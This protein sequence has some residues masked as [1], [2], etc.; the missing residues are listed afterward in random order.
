M[1][2]R[3]TGLPAKKVKRLN[4]QAAKTKNKK[5]KRLN[6]FAAKNLK[7]VTGKN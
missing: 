2:K 7:R 4:V 1:Q 5:Q 3:L 6:A